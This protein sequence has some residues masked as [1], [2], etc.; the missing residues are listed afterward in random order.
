MT[1]ASNIT[2]ADAQ[3]TP[4]THT[5]V[6]LGTDRDGVMWFEDQSAASAIGNWKVSVERRAPSGKLN[7]GMNSANRIYR[8]RIGLHEPV[9][10]TVSN[11]TVSGITPAP[12]LA[13]IAR[14]V[15]E[16]LLPERTVL[17]DRQ[18]MA[19]MLPLLLQNSQIKTLIETL[20]ILS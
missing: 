5:F 7:A 10:E 6:P 11:S 13:Y 14:G 19:K 9:L 20:G 3:A 17:L 12:Q 16:F 2:I 4:V 1:T 18:N 8:Y 15:V